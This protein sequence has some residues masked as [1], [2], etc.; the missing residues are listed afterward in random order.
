MSDVWEMEES[1]LRHRVQSIG[2][3]EAHRRAVQSKP[4]FGVIP[5]GGAAVGS[6]D[7]CVQALEGGDECPAAVGAQELMPS[8]R[9]GSLL[10]RQ[11]S[12]RS[13]KD[14]VA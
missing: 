12:G 13:V 9:I 10:G 3:Q 6:H 5:A 4:P 8:C 11:A 7:V 14:V 2:R 1:A